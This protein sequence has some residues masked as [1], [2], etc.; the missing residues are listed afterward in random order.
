[1]NWRRFAKSKRLRKLLL[2]LADE[3]Y[4]ESAH[5]A[6]RTPFGGELSVPSGDYFGSTDTVLMDPRIWI[7]IQK[8]QLTTGIPD[9]EIIFPFKKSTIIQTAIYGYVMVLKIS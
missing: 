3:I 6:I 9:W 8:M 1:M 4:A 2:Y 7:Y 5:A